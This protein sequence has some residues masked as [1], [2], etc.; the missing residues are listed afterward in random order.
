MVILF[1]LIEGIRDLWEHK[2]RSLLTLIGVA[3]GVGSLLAMYGLT[4]GMIATLRESLEQTGNMQ[5]M[6]VVPQE[7]PLE[8]IPIADQ[9][10]GITYRDIEAIRKSNNPLVTWIA[11][12]IEMPAR[13]FY[14][15]RTSSLYTYGCDQ[16]R[17]K[18]DRMEVSTG[19]YIT[20]LDLAQA[21]RVAVVG[22]TVA[23][24]LWDHPE[25]EAIG[26][27]INI[28]G[29]NFTVIGLFPRYA[30]QAQ[31]RSERE[32]V[33][34]RYAARRKE[35]HQKK[36]IWD[37]WPWK[38]KVID[39]PI[40]TMLA[41]FRSASVDAGG[42]NLGPDVKLSDFHV[43]LRRPEDVLNAGEQ[44][45][46]ILLKTHCG[47]EDFEIQMFQN[48]VLQAKKA[49][50]SAQINGGIIASIGLIV[51]GL[52]IMNIMLAS[53][54]DRIREIGIRRAVGAT[55]LHLFSQVM[56]ES[57]ILG[58]IGGVIGVL[59]G[60][61]ILKTLEL[62]APVQTHAVLGPGDMATSYGFAVLTG[63]LAGIY[64]AIKAARL[65][66]IQALFFD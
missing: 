8:Q 25:N 47:I 24:A 4:G 53:I 45:R 36:R 49:I 27:V 2:L 59:A 22:S 28:Q 56:I 38:N 3:L 18:M 50:H 13:V 10:P 5:K 48:E 46:N 21:N 1:G 33:E 52:G 51:G 16:E 29:I 19:R 44:V 40:T 66:V 23:A 17:L 14:H 12:S 6:K 57:I 15:G 39:I 64:P 20:D 11:P 61:G 7:P 35:R 42:V 62:L 31:L 41:T 63:L 60:L 58:A 9:S 34:A 55:P 32:G 54:V 30:T 65:S 43:G 37:P 26:S